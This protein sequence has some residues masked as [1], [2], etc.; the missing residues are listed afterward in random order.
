M[1]AKKFLSFFILSIIA[2]SVIGWIDTSP[3]WDDTG[4]TVFIILITSVTLGAGFPRYFWLWGSIIGVIIVGFNIVLFTNY[5]SSI[6]I[7]IA[8]VCSGMGAAIRKSISTGTT[9]VL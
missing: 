7:V 6:A 4:I 1:T 8:L 9:K 2:G 5:Q 3:H